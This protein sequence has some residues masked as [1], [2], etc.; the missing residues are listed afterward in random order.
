MTRGPQRPLQE[1]QE[2]IGILDIEDDEREP[3]DAAIATG[4]GTPTGAPWEQL[5]DAVD[6]EFLPEKGAPG[7]GVPRFRAR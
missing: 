1:G 5:I 2:L 3:D 7:R 4:M 6:R